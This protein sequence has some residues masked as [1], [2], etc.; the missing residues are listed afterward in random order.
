MKFYLQ[1]TNIVNIEGVNIEFSDEP[2]TQKGDIYVAERNV[3]PKLLT[4][5]S[6]DKINGIVHPQEMAYSYDI[7]ECRKIIGLK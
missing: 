1:N 2:P 3:G 7:R 6:I 4:V 5:R